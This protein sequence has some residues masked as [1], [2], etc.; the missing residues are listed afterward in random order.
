ME[1]S[2]QSLLSL[3]EGHHHLL[4]PVWF[5]PFEDAS[6]YLDQRGVAIVEGGVEETRELLSERFD[7]IFYTGNAEVGR[8]VMEAAARHLT[9]VTLELGG[10]SPAI[11]DRMY[12]IESVKRVVER[13]AEKKRKALI[14]LATGTGKTLTLKMA[15]GLLQPVGRQRPVL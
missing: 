9:P 13:F 15:A 8:I 7:H 4:G 5:L 6:R 2:R 1:S 14:V 12:Q 10:K 3:F 11:V